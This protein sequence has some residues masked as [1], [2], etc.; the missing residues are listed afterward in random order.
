MESRSISCPSEIKVLII[1]TKEEQNKQM[2]LINFC[3]QAQCSQIWL[4]A[5]VSGNRNKYSLLQGKDNKLSVAGAY[6]AYIIF[7]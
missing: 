4:K 5:C 7:S 2:H 6:I 3:L 1:N